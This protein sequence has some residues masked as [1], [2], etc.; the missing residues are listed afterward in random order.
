MHF[1][2]LDTASVYWLIERLDL[3]KAAGLFTCPKF[4]PIG[5]ADPSTYIGHPNLYTLLD[6]SLDPEKRFE[7]VRNEPYIHQ[8]KLVDDT[9]IS[10]FGVDKVQFIRNIPFLFYTLS[11]Y[12]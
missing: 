6:E 2:N 12:K 5:D 11:T 4:I 3:I 10:I 1:D 9:L 7:A 8:P